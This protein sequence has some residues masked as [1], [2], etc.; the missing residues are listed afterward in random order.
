MLVNRLIM[1]AAGCR[2]GWNE[3][4]LGQGFQGTGLRTTGL[5]DW[6]RASPKLQVLCFWYKV[7]NTYQKYPK[8]GEPM[9]R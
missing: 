7:V 2:L 8:E 6:V 1:N 9:I 3:N 5:D 4:I